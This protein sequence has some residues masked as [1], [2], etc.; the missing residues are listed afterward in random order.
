[1]ENFDKNRIE[2]II[3]TRKHAH[4]FYSKKSEVYRSFVEVE[5]KTY[6]DGDLSKLQKELIAIGIS[7]TINCE[8]CIV[9]RAWN[10]ILNKLLTTE[11]PKKWSSKRLKLALK[12]QEDQPRPQPCLP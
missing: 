2:A 12:W 1:M 8:S 9:H 4:A 3:K 6:K 10:G 7:M 5:Q 11:Q